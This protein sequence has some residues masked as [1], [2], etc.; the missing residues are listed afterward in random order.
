MCIGFENP[1]IPNPVGN[2]ENIKAIY[3]LWW[4]RRVSHQLRQKAEAA[5]KSRRRKLQKPKRQ[6]K[7]DIGNSKIEAAIENPERISKYLC[8]ISKSPLHANL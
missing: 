5:I 7:A 3:I 2:S 4:L 8:G 1:E 6:L